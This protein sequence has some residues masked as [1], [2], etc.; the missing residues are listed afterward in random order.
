MTPSHLP[1]MSQAI[2]KVTSASAGCGPCCNDGVTRSRPRARDIRFLQRAMAFSV[3]FLASNRAASAS[4]SAQQSL[5]ASISS[6]QT[7]PIGL[8][9]RQKEEFSSLRRCVAAVE[10]DPHYGV[11][12]PVWRE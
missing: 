1:H 5:A 9:G 10:L 8:N 3:G 11:K 7:S 6:S 12:T 4:R 2:R